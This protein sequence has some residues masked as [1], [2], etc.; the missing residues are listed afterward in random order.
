MQVIGNW[1]LHRESWRVEVARESEAAMK[2]E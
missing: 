2:P 1:I